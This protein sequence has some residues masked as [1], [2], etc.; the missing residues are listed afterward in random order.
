MG[1]GGVQEV[2]A[3][4]SSLPL[5]LMRLPSLSPPLQATPV[6]QPDL[7]AQPRPG[8]LPLVPDAE[9]GQRHQKAQA[10]VQ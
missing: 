8:L 6:P 10:G 9:W 5:A 3:T 1:C 2:L 4:A 7:A